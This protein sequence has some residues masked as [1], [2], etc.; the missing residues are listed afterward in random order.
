MLTGNRTDKKWTLTN[1]IFKKTENKLNLAPEYYLIVWPWNVPISPKRWCF[2]HVFY[3]CPNK[4]L[5]KRNSE[6]TSKIKANKEVMGEPRNKRVIKYTMKWSN[7]H[8]LWII[9]KMFNFVSELQNNS[10]ATYRLTSHER[11]YDFNKTDN[12]DIE[13]TRET[14]FYF[15]EISWTGHQYC[16]FDRMSHWVHQTSRDVCFVTDFQHC[17]ANLLSTIN[18]WET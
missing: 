11:C 8:D 2:V 1:N 15:A 10:L 6:C 12:F 16:I 5:S 13:N 14:K 3:L 9:K 7:S 17:S 4:T 18:R